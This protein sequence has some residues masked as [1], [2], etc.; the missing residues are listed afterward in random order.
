MLISK[1]M[2]SAINRQIGKEFGALLQRVETEVEQ[3]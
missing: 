3:D 1:K 2:N